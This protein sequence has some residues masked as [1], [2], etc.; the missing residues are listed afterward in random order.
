MSVSPPQV[1]RRAGLTL[2]LL[3]FAQ[4]IVS[5]DYNIVYVAL[6][7]IGRELQFTP[8]TLQWVISAY[9]VVYGGF[10]LLG[11]RASDLLGRRR[12]FLFGLAFYAVASLVGA[13][14]TEPGLLVAARAV[15]GL[16]G[17]FLFP[18]TLSLVTTTFA[19]GRARNLALSVWAGAGASGMVL[20]SLLGG[21][22][23]QAF[24]WESV[25]V[26]NVP[27]ALAAM[28]AA[29]PLLP[30]DD[31]R[32]TARRFDLPGALTATAGT[33]AIVF[34]LVQGPES[35][36]DTPVVVAAAG[37]G[38]VLLAAFIGI[39]RRS[40]DPLMPLRMFR[41]RNVSAGVATTF[42]FTATFSSIT[43]FFT[44]YLQT[45]RGY[46]AL[47][48]GLAFLAPCAVILV[49]S[50]AGGRLATRFGVRATLVGSLA[51]G[52]VGAA[53][54][55][56]AMV[57]DGSYLGLLPGLLVMSLGQGVVF[58]VM[59]AAAATGVPAAQQG[60]ASGLASTGQ[61][62]GTAVGLAVLV[63]IANAGTHGLAGEALREATT[64]GM[65]TAVLL[66]TA[67][68]VAMVLVALTFAGRSQNHTV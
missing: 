22:L 14:A 65:R 41:N 18:A 12:M 60:V 3:A 38:V 33:T 35:G 16:G 36:W 24:G 62:V 2:A 10:L 34:A 26:V 32:R 64:G 1:R 7:E 28:A 23:T 58:T 21:V 19:E 61:Q 47:A 59:F 43:Y 29:V 27:L 66:A 20:G 5:L 8:Q 67:G 53:G 68:I 45:V 17:A 51:L 50:L 39:E 44:V 37:V 42:L 49:G 54:M 48:T 9:V 15:Q 30:P 52:V 13:L 57:S 56:L 25:F 6:P 11:G 46:S 4:L 63:A 40:P 31:P 55:A